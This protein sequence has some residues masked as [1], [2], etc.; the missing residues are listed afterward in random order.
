MRLIAGILSVLVATALMLGGIVLIVAQTPRLSGGLIA[1]ATGPITVFVYGPLILGSI[2]AYWNVRKTPE[3]RRYFRRWF[4]GVLVLEALGATA[5]VIYAKFSAAPAWLPGLFIGGALVLLL[6][7]MLVGRLLLR[8]EEAN[9][10]AEQRWNPIGR[11]EIRRKILIV[12]ITFVG[13]LVLGIVVFTLLLAVLGDSRDRNATSVG[14]M[15]TFAIE[16]AFIAAAVACIL[17]TL[18]LNRRL[19]E[20]LGRDFGR[21]R[22]IGKVVL[23]NKKLDLDQAGQLAAARYA[24]IV[25][26]TLAFQLAYIT[27]LYLGIATQQVQALLSGNDSGLG[28]GFS[29]GLLIA[30]VVVLVVFF[31]LFARRISRARTYALDHANLTDENS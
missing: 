28:P 21:V 10:P 23:Q 20:N 27:L 19:R 25:S 17:V 7:A 2:T 13:G 30:L 29:I 4:I 24:V 6:V 1:L 5:I 31:P 11:E 16:F 9:P 14:V 8:H 12:A 18:P 15:L 26:V 22:Q 3:S